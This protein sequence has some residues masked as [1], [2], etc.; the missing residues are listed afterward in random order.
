MHWKLSSYV[1]WLNSYPSP[2]DMLLTQ[3][4]YFTWK[5]SYDHARQHIKKQRHYFGD[6]GP[7]SQNHGFSSSHVW[8]WELGYK[9]SWTP[10]NWCFWTV[11]LEKILKSPLDCK[12]I[13]PVHRKE[14]S[15]EYS[16]EGLMLKVQLQYFGHLMRRTDSLGK[17]LM[18]G[19]IEGRRRKGRQR[20][21]WLDGIT[22]S[23]DMSLSKLWKLVMDRETWLAAVHGVAKSWTR[24]SDWTDFTY[25]FS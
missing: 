7:S 24:L 12:E 13:Q 8:M 9:E 21:R 3:I 25:C 20:M 6:K 4:F 1:Y 23:I 22:D 15:P 16:L 17:T 2:S 18:L 11:V 5:K 14:I 19:K 10:K